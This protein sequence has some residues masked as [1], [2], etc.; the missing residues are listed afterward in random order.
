MREIKKISFVGGGRITYL[1]LHGLQ[2]NGIV[3][4]QVLVYDPS[5]EKQAKLQTIDVEH[6][7]S[8]GNR[9]FVFSCMQ[10]NTNKHIGG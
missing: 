5:A 2:R 6:G 4:D 9:F 3:P 7:V 8:I 1:L 10:I